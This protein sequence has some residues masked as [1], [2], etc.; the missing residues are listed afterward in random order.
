MF[1]KGR[2]IRNKLLSAFVVLIGIFLLSALLSFFLQRRINNYQNL[3]TDV[4]ELLAKSLL[5]RKYEQ[6]FLVYDTQ[7]PS[8]MRT[9]ESLN[10]K[11]YEK[12]TREVRETLEEVKG[13]PATSQLN[14]DDRIEEVSSLLSQYTQKTR[15]IVDKYLLRG[16]QDFGLE[17]KMRFAAHQL[18]ED[19]VLN[20]ALIL[21]LRRNEKDFLMRK[22]LAYA[23]KLDDLL[24]EL[25]QMYLD[26]SLTF[27]SLDEYQRKFQRIVKVEKEIGLTEQ[28]GLRGD[29][30]KLVAKIETQLNGIHYLSTQR[31]KSLIFY[32]NILMVTTI[33]L[34]LIV[35]I[36]FALYFAYSF[37]APIV[38]LDRIT[39][40]VVKDLRQQDKLLT[41]IKS[42]D[43]IGNLA[44]NFQVMLDKLRSKISQAEERSY[45]LE[46]Y[47]DGESRRNWH[48]EGLSIFNEILRKYQTDL[49]RQGFELI[50][51][52]VKYTQSSQGGFFVVREDEREGAYLDLVACYAYDRQKY[53]KKHIQK[54]EGLVGASWREGGTLFITDIPKDYGFITSGLGQARPNCLLIVPVKSDNQVQ[55]VIELVSFKELTQHEID[56]VEVLGEKIA[57]SIISL[58]SN[59]ET[60]RL[61]AKTEQIAN[62]AQ[63]R[64]EGLKKQIQN[65]EH[66]VHQF[67]QK[68]N[69]VSEEV[70]IYQS[71]ISKIFDGM[72]ITNE[73]FIITKVNRFIT[74]R[75]EYQQHEL[76]GQSVDI[77]IE[78]DY[79]NIIDLG[80]RRFRLSYQSFQQTVNGKVI[81]KVGKIHGVEMISGK[82]EIEDQLV[83]VFLFNEPEY[84]EEVPETEVEK[85]KA[86]LKTYFSTFG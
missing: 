31:T 19:N 25:K 3:R 21:T 47:I 42:N 82:L 70:F 2:K 64:E 52:L 68:L 57:T 63:Q 69:S 86:P 58:K 46:T 29:I 6:N 83:Y 30:S 33:L 8:F 39:Q 18:E 5:M 76:V 80:K 74:K 11:N 61:L 15:A 84:K 79:Q 26:D 10:L 1:R 24:N 62:E 50:S 32:A 43:E 28:A 77:L 49:N 55:G 59:E 34:C 71:I 12:N 85:V 36:V 38:A 54:G 73:K 23:T 13:N 53:L 4:N 45:Q 60:H 7:T 35:A 41:N 67:E 37:S 56:F 40:S 14:I 78:T 44:S 9:G 81:D 51:Q 22:D 20:R 16:Y 48:N 66:W 65:Y 72:I 17:G 27:H 75:F